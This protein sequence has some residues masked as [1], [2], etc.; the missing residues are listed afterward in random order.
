MKKIKLYANTLIFL[1]IIVSCII[2]PFDYLYPEYESLWIKCEIFFTL[3]FIIEYFIRWFYSEDKLRYP[4]TFY[5]IVDMLAIIPSLLLITNN[6]MLLRLFRIAR[7]LRLLKLIRYNS[8]FYDSFNNLKN[9]FSSFRDEY[10]LDNL[11]TVFILCIIALIAGANL[12]YFTE[13]EFASG[14]GP[15]S[16]YWKSYWHMVIVLI[17]GIEDKEPVSLAGKIEVTILLIA[18][19]C[20]VGMVTAEI[21]S[22]L[23]RKLSRKGKASLKPLNSRMENHIVILGFNSHL[24]YVIRQLYKAYGGKYYILCANRRADEIIVTIPH[25]YKKVVVVKGI[26]VYPEVLKNADISYARSVIIL[27]EDVPENIKIDNN[28]LMKAIAVNSINKNVPITVQI[29]SVDSMKYFNIIENVDFIISSVYTAKL[30]SQG[31]LNPGVTEIYRSLMTFSSDS[32]E[33]YKIRIPEN[34]NASTFNGITQYLFDN[35]EAIIPVGIYRYSKEK[36]K[37]VCRLNPLAYESGVVCGN[38]SDIEIFPDDYLMVI[39]YREPFIEFDTKKGK[40]FDIE[41]IKDFSSVKYERKDLSINS[42]F[43][44]LSNNSVVICN[45]NSNLKNIVNELLFGSE[46]NNFNLTL[47]VQSKKLWENKPNWHPENCEENIKI[48]YGDCSD[49][50]VLERA[51]IKNC[52]AAI[53]LADPLHGKYADAPSTLVA[54][55]IE[56]MNPEVHTVMEL[57]NSVNREYIDFD[58]INEVVC[59]GDIT[60]KLIAQNCYHPGVVD[61]FNDLLTSGKGTPQIFLPEFPEIFWNKTY[62]EIYEFFIKINKKF[63]PIGFVKKDQYCINP[64]FESTFGMDTVIEKNDRLIIIAHSFDKKDL[65]I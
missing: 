12:V 64:L 40:D 8:Y 58:T 20:V 42:S 46:Q 43:K 45:I 11:G 47:I 22:I 13:T 9:R 7:F 21:V 26:S 15:Y 28:A 1:L 36:E 16:N 27:S 23:V 44:N 33:F 34:F 53:I 61:V 35:K 57:I 2:I 52:G 41:L 62:K 17:S 25:I 4:I 65:E 49:I 37:F 10:Q 59:L 14:P 19:I 51:G 30:I 6:F 60:E 18:G 29:Q 50:S 31:V 55:A 24:D 3:I 32:N 5:A 38:Q 56:K 48:I 39:A 54:M 63:I